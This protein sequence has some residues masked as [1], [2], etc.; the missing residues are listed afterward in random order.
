M[1]KETIISWISNIEDNPK[2]RAELL[3]E[4]VKVVYD[5]VKFE[6]P[7]GEGLDGRDGEERR[8]LAKIVD[9][10]EHHYFEMIKNS[11]KE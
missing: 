7:G 3:R 2:A 9:A 8:S 10:T 1:K 6:R 5:F 11:H 4:M